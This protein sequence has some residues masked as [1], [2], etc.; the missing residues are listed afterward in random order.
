MTRR[1]RRKNCLPFNVSEIP[2]GTPLE[3]LPTEVAVAGDL[4]QRQD[5]DIDSDSESDPEDF[6]GD[7]GK[8]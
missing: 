6:D 4:D 3:D 2:D 7:G 8:C 5:P 1:K